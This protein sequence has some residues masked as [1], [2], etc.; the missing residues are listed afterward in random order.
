MKTPIFNSVKSLNPKRNL[1][2]LSHER[3]LTCNFG[4]LIPI[5][6]EPVIPSDSF[7]IQ[8]EVLMRLYPLIAPIM[9][10][11]NLSVHFFFVPHR[12]IFKNYENFFTGGKD[13]TAYVANPNIMITDVTK[14]QVGIGTLADYLGIPPAPSQTFSSYSL[15]NALPFR[16][17]QKIWNDWYRDPN[18]GTESLVSDSDNVSAEEQDDIVLLR[19]RNKQRDYFTTALPWTQRGGEVLIPSAVDYK[20]RGVSIGTDGSPTLVDG[21]LATSGGAGLLA[22]G[23]VP[24]NIDNID[25]LEITVNDLRKAMRMQ[26]WLERNARSGWRY[27]EQVLSHFSVKSDDLRANRP[28]YIGGGRQPVSISEVLSTF[29][30]DTIP[31]GEMAGHGISVGNQNIGKYFVKEHGFIMGLLSVLPTNTYM[32]GIPRFMSYRSKFD[33]PFPEFAHLGEQPVYNNEIYKDYFQSQ[34]VGEQAWAYQSRYAEFKFGKDSVHGD[35]RKSLSFWHMAQDF[36][37]QPPLND[38]FLKGDYSDIENRIFGVSDTGETHKLM[39]NVYHKVKAVRPLPVFGEPSV[40][41]NRLVL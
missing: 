5:Y 8:S 17:Y 10:R 28:V 21:P 39:I 25:T 23:G 26:T 30:N 20:D 18:F 12:I 9:H 32:N 34:E 41:M 2:D 6:C 33:Y 4:D 3:K 14:A 38:E 1:F 31:Q 24:S 19:K 27:V 15:F 40:I 36:A 7:R 22:T 11:I 13:G 29:S 16:A 35:F 37:A